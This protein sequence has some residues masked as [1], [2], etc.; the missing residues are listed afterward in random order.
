VLTARQGV[1]LETADDAFDFAAKVLAVMDPER[2][3]GIGRLARA[4]ILAD[5]AWSSRLA[6]LDD[7]FARADPARLPPLIPVPLRHLAAAPASTR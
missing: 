1:E 5:Y 7:L 6:R 3:D 4:R 2:G